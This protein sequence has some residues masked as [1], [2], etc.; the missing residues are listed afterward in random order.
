MPRAL[1]LAVPV[2]I[3]A[4]ALTGC[5][6]GEDETASSPSATSQALPA[7]VTG[8]LESQLTK[9]M[10][11]N[12]VPGGAVEVCV[13]GYED[14]ATAQGVADVESNTAMTTDMYW[15]LRSVT[16][17]YTVTLLL[18]LVDQGK[19]SLDDTIDKWVDGVPSG[20]E[21]TLRQLADMSS[22]VPEYTTRAWI[23]DYVADPQ[24]AFTTQELIDYANAEPAQFPP[25]A[26]KVYTNTNTLLLG[27]VVAQQY[28]QPFDQVITEQI[29][30]QLGLTGTRYETA[31]NDWPGEHPTGYQPDDQGERQ[32]QDNNFTTLGPAG[33]MTST[34]PD[35]C[36]WGDALGEGTLIKPQT[37]QAR[38]Q[39]APLEKGPEYDTYGLG[40][41]T[42]EGWVGHTGEGFGHTVLVMH[43]PESGATV[44]VGMNVSSLGKHVPTRYFRKIAPILDSVPPAG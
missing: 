16:K 6:S 32:P 19:V 21:V 38:L 36:T 28:G 25:G 37:Q 18:Q 34:L 20:D 12:D 13:P 29:I 9:T 5:S 17:S 27:E 30:E 23:R 15:P 43:N 31:P 24:R 41:G 8:A 35:M 42:L 10:Q 11:R 40:I 7:D 39:G 44:A 14:W 2:L 3:A 33:A 1:R 26:K 22:G 4:V